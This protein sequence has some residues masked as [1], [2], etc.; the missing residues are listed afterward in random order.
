M[1]KTERRFFD[2]LEELIDRHEGSAIRVSQHRDRACVAE[3]REKW[4]HI[5]D[6]AVDFHALVEEEYARPAAR[7]LR[8]AAAVPAV[9]DYFRGASP[10]WIAGCPD[11]GTRPE[12]TAGRTPAAEALLRWREDR[13]GPDV[14]VVTGSPG[15]GKSH[16]LSWFTMS[17]TKSWSASG[18]GSGP[19]MVA[20]SLRV[21]GVEDCARHLAAQLGIEVETAGD[22]IAA[23][24]AT[25][26]PALI[27]L[28][29]L[30]ESLDPGRVISEL[31]RPLAANGHVALVVEA[32]DSGALGLT[33]AHYVLDLD[34]PRCT[35]PEL[36]NR[37]YAEEC[38]SAPGASPFTAGQVHPSPGVAVI[39][40]RARGTD[41]G[42]GHPIAERAAR[43]W[44]NGL[45]ET[46]RDA[47]ATLALAV[48][49]MGLATWRLLHC[50]RHPHD[51]RTA[52]RGVDEAAAHLPT[53]EL[54]IPAY[55]LRI[56]SLIGA[57]AP[58]AAD[59]A[60]AHRELAAIMRGWPASDDLGPADYVREHLDDHLRLAGV[61]TP[62]DV[63]ALNPCP[64]PVRVTRAMLEAVFGT[65]GLLRLTPEQ[66]HPHI[67][68]TSTRRFLTNVGVPK[69]GVVDDFV[70]DAPRFLEPITRWWGEDSVR[71]LRACSGLPGDLD[72]VFVLDFMHT[73]YLLLD[74][75]TGLV[76]EVYE[77]LEEA[78]VTHRNVESYTYFAYAIARDRGLW[79]G[80][81][82]HPDASCWS[83]DNL[84]LELRTYESHAM[85]DPRQ[86]W[87]PLLEEF[88]LDMWR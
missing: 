9:P 38:R 14:C 7:L 68:H 84:I 3:V 24:A 12:Y 78:F 43:A 59:H 86:L 85:A 49:P 31:I 75:T 46:A 45:S 30:H 2:D 6:Q 69:D 55:F 8:R 72:S 57:V 48:A 76:H 39:A 65:D 11:P 83:G 70:D 63:A 82:A 77:S 88:Y 20:T 66:L 21:M 16:L 29:E 67:T 44:L 56:P 61:T 64:P 26:V 51:P 10:A 27:T 53:A 28:A 32:R 25:T 60:R 17:T 80:R 5:C 1:R 52:S 33:D 35:D 4:E 22:P 13:Y 23:V 79:R 87:G 34:D 54:G 73:W 58:P 15:S 37:W 47:A 42:P 36:F 62:E 41:P 19:T 74:G 18:T 40:A 81:D 50:G 71:N